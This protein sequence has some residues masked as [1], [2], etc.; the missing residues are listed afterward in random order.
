MRNPAIQP[1]GFLLE[2]SP[3]WLI[4]AASENAH[5]FFGEYPQRM[6]GNPLVD[7]TLAQ[8]LHDLRNSLSRQRGPGGVSRAY[9]VRLVDAPRHFDIA[10]Q[11]SD[12]LILLEGLNSADSGTG[13]ALGS[14]GRLIDGLSGL[15]ENALLEGAARRMRA[16]TGF[17]RV[18]VTLGRKRIV[19]SRSQWPELDCDDPLP[20][21]LADVSAQPIGVF[22]NDAD[23]AAGAALLRAPSQAHCK[24]LGACGMQSALRVA[25][26]REGETVGHFLCESRLARDPSFELHAAAE[27]FAQIVG[28]MLRA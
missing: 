23:Q 20:A 18:T 2:L 9:R 5:A 22:G 17:D 10:F 28:T 26:T 19:S 25:I 16:L 21:V 27:L 6:V 8:P 7:F 14:V 15:E 24:A 3:D 4:Q 12:K 13:D 11:A 1:S